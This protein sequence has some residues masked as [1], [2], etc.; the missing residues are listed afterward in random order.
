MADHFFYFSSSRATRDIA[1][2]SITNHQ[3]YQI[4]TYS[5]RFRTA[6]SDDPSFRPRRSAGAFQYVI[7]HPIAS[8]ILRNIHTD[9]LRRAFSIWHTST[10][11]LCHTK[12]YKSLRS[13]HWLNVSRVTSSFKCN[14]CC[15]FKCNI[16]SAHI[17]CFPISLL[18]LNI[19]FF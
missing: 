9:A 13:V 4:S 19:H 10:R 8:L 14:K 11:W 17:I 16:G 6:H 18:F 3:E 2:N 7:N 1:R 5:I 12:W 15:G